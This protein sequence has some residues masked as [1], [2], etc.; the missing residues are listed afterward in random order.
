MASV[1]SGSSSQSTA[2]SG[3][4]KSTVTGN[5]FVTL[6]VGNFF[7]LQSWGR[8]VIDGA[9][10]DIP[11]P[12]SMN[13]GNTWSWS[14]TR[15]FTHDDNGYRG[16]KDVSVSFRVDGTSLHQSSAGAGTQ[17]AID[18][19]RRPAQPGFSSITRS[20][21]SLNVQIGSVSSPAAGLYY[22][23]EINRN[24]EGWVD[25]RGGQNNTYSSLTLGA[26]YQLRTWAGNNDG[27][28]GFT[29]SGTYFI[30]NVPSAPP[31]ISVTPPSGLSATVTTGT[32][33][34]N[35][36]GITAYFV[37][38]SADNGATWQSAQQMT[39]QSFTYTGL[40]PGAT[41]RFRTYAVNEMGNGAFATSA[42]TFVPAGGKKWTGTE[43]Q[44]SNTA[45]RFNGAAWVDITTAKRWNGSAWI[46]LT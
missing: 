23:T 22:R 40:T 26:N 19:D 44:V 45:K 15:E 42:S 7:G 37:Q 17:G 28:T 2:L 30:P 38:A 43:W 35:G 12:T 6:T 1:T 46:D 41:Y 14:A 34:N 29:Y 8:V 13:Q 10:Y 36:A 21:N 11:G 9:V 16:P 25:Q 31:S 5:G 32:A 20:T 39:N 24:N 33:S 27:A 18:Y 4:N 3:S